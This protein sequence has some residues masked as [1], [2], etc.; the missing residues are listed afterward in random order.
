MKVAIRSV[1][2]WL[3]VTGIGVD[4]R[5]K[6]QRSCGSAGPHGSRETHPSTTQMGK[7]QTTVVKEI[8]PKE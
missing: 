6:A 3:E 5:D 1:S 7:R 8:I 4:G 2:H